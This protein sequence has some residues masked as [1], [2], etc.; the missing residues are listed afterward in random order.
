MLS[1]MATRLAKLFEQT[2]ELPETVELDPAWRILHLG[3]GDGTLTRRML[4]NCSNVVV[5]DFSR[6]ALLVAGQGGYQTIVLEPG[7]SLPFGDAEFDL[8]VSFGFI[9]EATGPREDFRRII[10]ASVFRN[11]AWRHQF[12]MAQEIQRVSRRFVVQTSHRFNPFDA[13]DPV[14]V[15]GLV[16]SR[17]RQLQAID[18][19][20][21]LGLARR[22]PPI[23]NALVPREMGQLFPR[24]HII[25][26]RRLRLPVS[27]TAVQA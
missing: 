20:H 12:H 19:A 15:A 1:A 7:A 8:L 25:V 24:A 3:G 14:H 10:N 21:R 9:E 18:L 27:I 22:D 16:L 23:T 4:P 17:E 11:E 26:A 13:H 5:A 6:S 2:A